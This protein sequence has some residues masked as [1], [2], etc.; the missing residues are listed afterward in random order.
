MD[1]DASWEWGWG[2]TEKEVWPS[3]SAPSV[4]PQ[5]LPFLTLNRPFA[6]EGQAAWVGGSLVRTPIPHFSLYRQR[7]S[8]PPPFCGLGPAGVCGTFSSPVAFP[9]S[10]PPPL[11]GS[12]FPPWPFRGRPWAQT[13]ASSLSLSGSTSLSRLQALVPST[14]KDK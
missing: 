9:S 4:S 5:T 11:Q 7:R 13:L 10:L 1:C 2:Q 12:A 6:A 3:V 14:S 8:P